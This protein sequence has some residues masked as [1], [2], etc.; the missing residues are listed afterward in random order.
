MH[1]MKEKK[2]EFRLFS[3]FSRCAGELNCPDKYSKTE[4]KVWMYC[5]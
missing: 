2:Y 5:N 4:P 1:L 3:A